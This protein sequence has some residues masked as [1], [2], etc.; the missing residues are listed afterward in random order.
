MVV[1]TIFVDEKFWG[2]A[3]AYEKSIEISELF[4]YENKFHLLI[5]DFQSIDQLMGIAHKV[6]MNINAGT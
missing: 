6:E 1:A 4:H 5:T 3:I 2:Y